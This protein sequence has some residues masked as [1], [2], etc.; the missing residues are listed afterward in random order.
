MKGKPTVFLSRAILSL[1]GCGSGKQSLPSPACFNGRVK[2]QE[3]IPLHE[4][5]NYQ[6][7]A[8]GYLE[9]HAR[10][11]RT[12]VSSVKPGEPVRGQAPR[13]SYATI[14]RRR[15]SRRMREPNS[16]RITLAS[17]RA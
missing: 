4:T 9:G 13:K 8:R 14:A 10:R 17:V 3:K 6:G 16:R 7:F 1:K 2:R 5:L 12:L 11:E 15:S